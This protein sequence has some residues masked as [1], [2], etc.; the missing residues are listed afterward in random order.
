MLRK[1]N[2][3]IFFIYRKLAQALCT[4]CT[5]AWFS[6]LGVRFGK[7]FVTDSF[8]KV[9]VGLK[10]SIEFGENVILNNTVRSNPVGICSRCVLVAAGPGTRLAIGDNV[11][12]SG[13][14][15]VAHTGISIGRGTIIGSDSLIIDSDFH[16]LSVADRIADRKDT[17]GRTPIRIG[18]YV[19]I[20]ARSTILKGVEIGDGTIIAAGSVVTRSFGP[21]LLVG[22]NPAKTIKSIH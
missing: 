4:T 2:N 9:H 19:W 12:I 1:L 18:Q 7:G 11:G 21:N 20:G 14:F 15:I 3:I 5:K 6:I 17:I 16:P 10:S 22:G 13:S 8:P